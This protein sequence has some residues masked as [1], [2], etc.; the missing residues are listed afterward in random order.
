MVKRFSLKNLPQSWQ[1]VVPMLLLSLG[2]H[3]LL[4]AIPLSQKQAKQQPEK[5]KTATSVEVLPAG[6]SGE[7]FSPKNSLIPGKNSAANNVSAA[8]PTIPQNAPSSVPPVSSPR[9]TSPPIVPL[10]PPPDIK[11]TQAPPPPLVDIITPS[12][13]T[14]AKPKIT[15]APSPTT[16]KPKISPTPLI[17]PKSATIAP[18]PGVP[19][20]NNPATK[21]VVSLPT[22]TQT[23]SEPTPSLFPSPNI[24]EDPYPGFPK[25]PNTK[26]GKLGVFHEIPGK[27]RVV[28]TS[29]SFDTVVAFFE[30]ELATKGYQTQKTL[31][32][33]DTKVYLVLQDRQ[34]VYL[35]L[36]MQDQPGTLI[37]I[38][39]NQLVRKS[40]RSLP[41]KTP[42]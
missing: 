40:L 15:A 19:A 25:Y 2:L 18:S 16:A 31:D 14:A 8:F 22:P 17:S 11:I 32:E 37:A 39:P 21:K 7:I 34:I 12:S 38:A 41:Q 6:K 9:I 1:Q 28:Q 27:L 23:Y 4:F 24:N 10:S 29:D 3:G 42:N 36:F 30:Q 35:H 20:K 33:A 13:S 26:P 5:E